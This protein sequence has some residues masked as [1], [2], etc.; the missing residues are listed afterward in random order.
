MKTYL[1]IL[2]ALPSLLLRTANAESKYTKDQVIALGRVILSA[3][4]NKD[5]KAYFW[6][7]E[8]QYNDKTKSWSYLA[9]HIPV[10]PGGAIHIF[11][12]READ[13]FYRLGWISNQRT[14]S[15]YD[16]FRIQSSVRGKL[17]DLIENYKKP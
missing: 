11:E 3:D 10:T 7:T 15:G 1:Q 9:K 6:D 4:V 12:I 16:K 5:Y 17:T 2:I 13:C 8:P 14:S